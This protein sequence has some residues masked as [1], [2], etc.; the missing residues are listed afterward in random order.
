MVDRSNHG[1]NSTLSGQTSLWHPRSSLAATEPSRC[2]PHV[3]KMRLLGQH[4]TTE[5]TLGYWASMRLL[6]LHET[7]GVAHDYEGSTRLLG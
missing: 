4:E 1:E 2:L 6:G 7:T 3:S 5:V